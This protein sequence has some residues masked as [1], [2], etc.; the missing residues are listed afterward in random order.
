[1]QGSQS[2]VTNDIS[3]LPLGTNGIAVPRILVAEDHEI[4]LEIICMMLS[5]L[6]VS[7][8]KAHNG[9]E[10]IN[11]VNAAAAAGAMYSVV[12]VDFSMPEMGGIETTR[13]LRQLGYTPDQLPILAVTA[14]I[15][16][17]EFQSFIEAGGQAFLTKPIKG[18]KLTSAIAQWIPD[19]LPEKLAPACWM[20]QPLY[21]RYHARKSA[22]LQKMDGMIDSPDMVAKS[23][24]D[25]CNMLHNL[26]G[27]AGV[28][29]DEALSWA[30]ARCEVALRLAEPQEIRN[31]LRKYKK[32]FADEY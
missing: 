26:A 23:V 22:I 11:M 28:F 3:R 30:A 18:A 12:L 9:I 20:D 7:T 21:E 6:G 32:A 15:D 14:S 25:V 4:G 31:I 8:C 2:L 5:R 29:G 19:A 27:T 24:E 10:A 1:M 13:Q 16:T 17:N